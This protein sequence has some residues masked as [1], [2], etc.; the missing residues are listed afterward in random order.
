MFD[1]R[2]VQTSD[3]STNA[4]PSVAAFHKSERKRSTPAAY[5]AR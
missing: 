3:K 2:M 4:I 1:G 5:K